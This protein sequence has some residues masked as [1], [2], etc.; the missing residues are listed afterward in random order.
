MMPPYLV[1]TT[2]AVVFFLAGTL[3]RRPLLGLA[4][5]LLAASAFYLGL[6]PTP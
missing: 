3:K 5:G 1:M 2:I 4:L 6:G